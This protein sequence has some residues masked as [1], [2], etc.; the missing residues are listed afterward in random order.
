MREQSR[1]AT[2]SVVDLLIFLFAVVIGVVVGAAYLLRL[3]RHIAFR[4]ELGK[5]KPIFGIAIMSAALALTGC[6]VSPQSVSSIDPSVHATTFA[7]TDLTAT[8]SNY[9]TTPMVSGSTM[10]TAY[11]GDQ[12]D[13][14]PNLSGGTDITDRN[15]RSCR[16][17]PANLNGTVFLDCDGR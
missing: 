5:M 7:G 4:E 10:I 13:A 11:N 6:Y 1:E 12:Y 14:R 9:T 2:L 15:G 8:G 16:A 17:E 3:F